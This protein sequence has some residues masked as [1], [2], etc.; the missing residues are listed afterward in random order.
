MNQTEQNTKDIAEIK[1]TL[2]V[3]KDNHLA[4][5]EKDMAQMDKRIEKIDN[6]IWWVLGLLVASMVAGF[7]GDKI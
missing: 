3:M 5:I 1:T 4:H 6:R 2:T 7:L